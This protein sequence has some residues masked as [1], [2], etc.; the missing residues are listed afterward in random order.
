MNE[1][2]VGSD[3]AVIQR[4]AEGG[5]AENEMEE[6]LAAQRDAVRVGTEYADAYDYFSK[7]LDAEPKPIEYV[8]L[9]MFILGTALLPVSIATSFIGDGFLT[10]MVIAMVSNGLL[11]TSIACGFLLGSRK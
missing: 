2:T 11:L 9:V 3:A 4:L 7:T 10:A 5:A 8:V 6:L 1:N